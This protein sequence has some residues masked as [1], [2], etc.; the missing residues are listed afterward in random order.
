MLSYIFV[1]LGFYR[2]EKANARRYVRM[3]ENIIL[4]EKTEET[5]VKS[6]SSRHHKPDKPKKSKKGLI[7]ALAIVLALAIIA[8]VMVFVVYGGMHIWLRAELGEGAP[9]A[10]EFLKGEGEASFASEPDVSLTEEGSYLLKLKSGDKYRPVWLIVRDTKAP[11]GE[12][13]DKMITI[14]DKELKPEDALKNVSDASEYSVKWLTEPEYGKAG[15]YD[16]EIELA[17]A[18]GNERTVKTKVTVLGAVYVLEHEMGQPRPSIDDFM[19]VE[20]EDAKLV[21]DLDDIKWDELGDSTVK[22][23][24]D[25]KSYTSTLR[26]VD[27][28]APVPDLVPLAVLPDA[29]PEAAEL[30]IGCEDASEVSYEF[31]SELKL[32]KV[33]TV[34]CTVKATDA[35]GNTTEDDGKILVCDVLAEFE[36]SNELISEDAVLEQ[37]GADYAGYKLESEPFMLNSLGA[38]ALTFTKGDSK[39]VVG[40]TVKDTTAPTA[41]GIDC[42][43]STGYYCQPIKFVTNIAD[44]SAVKARFVNEPDWNVEG[45]Q[46]V[47]IVLSDRAGNET[48]V[49]AKAVISPDETAPVIYAAR[50]RYCY[51]GEPVAYFKEVFAED[52][53]DPEPELDV[54]KSK[55]NAKKIGE[56]DVTYTARDDEGNESSVTVKF[57]FIEKKVTDAQLEKEVDRVLKE[58]LKDGMSLEQQAYAIYDYCYSN[59]TYWGT[60]DKTD[61]KSEAYRGLTEGVGDCF[62]F[63]SASYALLQ[64]IDCGVLSVERLNGATQHFWCLVNLGT[65]WYHFDTCNVGPQHLRCFMK[66]SEE[67]VQYSVQYWRFDTTLYPELETIPYAMEN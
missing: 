28:T 46:E 47:E 32:S 3:D 44:V 17:D 20:R 25:G 26:I 33:G 16:C 8:A 24:F 40:V 57:K 67:L 2:T 64:K 19:V 27:T 59:I 14:D 4:E 30:V 1:E 21:T 41:E 31:T 7:I 58:I 63:Y 15:A 50:D 60:S 56:Y 9:A 51:V 49:K 43:C 12:S 36:A 23:A 66:T 42:P 38:H 18:C 13:A 35:A 52:N 34:G 54:D 11:E 61:W 22:I 45:E 37:L 5:E 62:T 65:G 55:V 10:A 29:E 39:V 6:R 53:A 48:T